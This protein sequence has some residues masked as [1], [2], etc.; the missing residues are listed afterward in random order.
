MHLNDI[1]TLHAQHLR[2]GFGTTTPDE[3]DY[4]QR[5]IA[6]HKPKRFV[7]IGTASGL[8]TGFIARFLEENGGQSVTSIDLSAKFFG[9][10]GQPVGYLARD[11]YRGDSVKI[12]ILPR[13]SALDL[14]DLGGPWD[15]AFIDANH[16]HPWPMVDTLALAPHL[17][18]PK[19]VVHHDL[20]LYRRFKY[21]RGVGPRVLFNEMPDS[22]RHADIAGD[23]NIFSIDLTLEPAIFEEVAIGSL[24]MPWTARPSLTAT[25]I[26]RFEEILEAHYSPHLRAEFRECQE[27]YRVSVPARAAFA[28]RRALAQTLE[29]LGLRKR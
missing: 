24:S 28:A 19:I 2:P 25:E 4:I 7:E 9:A 21:L 11:I 15:M 17:T 16:Q 12:D 14:G 26:A 8:S 20:Q 13:K 5:L 1:E 27:T 3:L 18:G 10:P 22:H 23:W 6:T 29:T